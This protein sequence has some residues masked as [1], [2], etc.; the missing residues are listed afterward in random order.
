MHAAW[1][2]RG[3]PSLVSQLSVCT[4]APRISLAITKQ[5]LLPQGLPAQ[6]VSRLLGKASGPSS[7]SSAPRCP[8]T[9][10]RA[11]CDRPHPLTTLPAFTCALTAAPTTCGF[12]RPHP[13]FAQAC[14]PLGVPFLLLSPHPVTP[15]FCPPLSRKVGSPLPTPQTH[16]DLTHVAVV[17][18]AASSPGD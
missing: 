12:F 14:S 8:R 10:A 2:P 7:S 17:V 3:E 6:P 18:P 5:M 4:P 16:V 11:L 15:K 1:E 9:L 13:A